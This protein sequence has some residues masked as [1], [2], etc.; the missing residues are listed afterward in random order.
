MSERYDRFRGKTAF[1]F[2]LKAQM[3]NNIPTGIVEL[4][5]LVDI[6]L[7]S[8][9]ASV[10]LY[11]YDRAEYKHGNPLDQINGIYG[12]LA[13]RECLRELGLRDHK[14]FEYVPRKLNHWGGKDPRPY[15]FK[16]NG[17]EIE[18]VTVKPQHQ[19]C[20]VKDTEF[21]RKLVERASET[22][23]VV[24]VQLKQFECYAEIFWQGEYRWFRIDAKSPVAIPITDKAEIQD[25]ETLKIKPYGKAK[26]GWYA[27]LKQVSEWD[28]SEP[29][30]PP[31]TEAPGWIKEL[32]QMPHSINE[33]WQI[34][35]P[36]LKAKPKGLLDYG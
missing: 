2:R 27:T 8:L 7:I 28:Y 11:E 18:I 23:Y 12:E 3:R 34:V 26:V 36:S 15:D 22:D 16:I 13:F 9:Y 25:Y 17:R 32:N 14:D 4:T 29:P 20:I 5:E 10:A 6:E 33:F 31:T 1:I 24:A 35:K 21:K 30:N 19:F